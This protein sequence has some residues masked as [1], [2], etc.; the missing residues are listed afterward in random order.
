MGDQSIEIHWLSIINSSVLV[1]LLTV[2]LAI[3]LVKILKKDFARY[4]ELDEEDFGGD[5][6]QVTYNHLLQH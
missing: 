2:F 3:I 4:L 5:A 1:V 6:E